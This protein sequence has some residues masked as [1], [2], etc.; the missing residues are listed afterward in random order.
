[1]SSPV[2]IKAL[3]QKLTE[4][5]VEFVLIGGVAG[6]AHGAARVTFDLDVVYRRTS[7]NYERLVAALSTLSPYLRGAPAG[8]PFRWDVP[9]IERGLNFTLTTTI[10]PIDLLGEV[11]GGGEYEDLFPDA[12]MA[13]AFGHTCRV[14]DLA[15][16]IRTKRA[17]GRPKDIEAIAELEL[18]L[19]RQSQPP[20]NTQ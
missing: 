9:T 16:L 13:N 3:L 7:K 20:R 19:E 1:M 17:A 18:L 15:S 11:T 8:L 2:D 5:G 4:H 14:I 12:I 10:G 6:V